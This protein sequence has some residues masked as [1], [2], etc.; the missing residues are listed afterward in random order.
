MPICKECVAVYAVNIGKPQPIY[1]CRRFPP[2]IKSD[3]PEFSYFPQV[4]AFD[5]CIEFQKNLVKGEEDH[6]QEG[7]PTEQTP[8]EKRCFSTH[9]PV[10]GNNSG[11][12]PECGVVGSGHDRDC[13]L[14]SM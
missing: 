11:P 8:T 4:Q 6:G 3:Q 12:C 13:P 2:Q 9:D 1:Y 10:E 5:W 14:N 7:Q